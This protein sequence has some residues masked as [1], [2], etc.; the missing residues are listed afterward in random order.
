MSAGIDRYD[1][2]V[3]SD[4]YPLNAFRLSY[5][6]NQTHFRTEFNYNPNNKHAINFGVHSIYYKIHPGSFQPASAQSLVLP[7][8]VPQEQALES[9]VYIGDRYAITP[10]L[11]VNAGIRYSMFSNLGPHEVYHYLPGS[12]RTTGS[13]VDTTQVAAG[14]QIKTYSGPEI[15]LAMRYSLSLNSSVKLSYNTLRQYIHTLSN[16]TAISPTDIWKLSDAN[17]PPQQGYQ[18]SLGYYHN[19]SQSIETSIEVYYKHMAHY[20]DYKSGALL[21]MNKHIETDVINT[22]G[23]AYGAEFMIKKTEGKLNG[24]LSYTFSST[25]LKMDDPIAGETINN[26]NAYPAN[27]DKPHNINFIGNYRFS[28]RISLSLNA[29]YSTGRPITI[30]IVK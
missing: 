10:D 9:A 30:P 27:F 21:V 26:G 2:S 1:Y 11:S 18:V 23:E 6:I 12:P 20:L 8:K 7:D 4:I 13:I 16:T 25:R 28:H 14:K 15:R 3:S 5:D 24:W 29:V 22:R 19:F 17:I